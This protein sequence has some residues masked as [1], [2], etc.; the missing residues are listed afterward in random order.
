MRHRGDATRSRSRLV[1][2]L[3]NLG[4]REGFGDLNVR[5][6]LNRLP[7]LLDAQLLLFGRDQDDA[8]VDVCPRLDG[9]LV[10]P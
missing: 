9:V 7:E 5:L 2:R 1:K 6:N 8:H 3:E 10:Q 4:I